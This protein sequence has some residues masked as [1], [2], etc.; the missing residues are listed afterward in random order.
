LI[1]ASWL[2]FSSRRT[3]SPA[4]RAFFAGIAEIPAVSGFVAADF[5]SVIARLTGMGRLT[6]DEARTTFA[7]F[8]NWRSRL[9]DD[10]D[11]TSD[12]IRVA[13][14]IIRRL[15]LNIRAPDAF[16]L[17]VA[18]RL[19]ASIAAFDRRMADNAQALGIPVAAA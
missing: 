15:D 9:A 19:S 10:V 8:D 3:H 17:A 5:A 13:T 2:V 6:E 14:A 1:P 18:M 16:N 12:D 7:L 4:A 11:T